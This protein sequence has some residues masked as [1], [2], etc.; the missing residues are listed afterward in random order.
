MNARRAQIILAILL[1]FLSCNDVF[2]QVET[3]TSASATISSS[4]AA[5]EEAQSFVQM[6]L[7]QVV[8]WK[9]LLI[10][11]K[12]SLPLYYSVQSLFLLSLLVSNAFL[13]FFILLNNTFF[14]VCSPIGRTCFISDIYNI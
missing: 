13:R 12:L 3:A 10:A 11:N 2:A 7:S 8:S 9:Q 1:V 5:M 14:P 6:Q 4:T